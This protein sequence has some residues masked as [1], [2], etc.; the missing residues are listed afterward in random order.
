MDLKNDATYRR[1]EITAEQVESIKKDIN[2]FR[3]V[4]DTYFDSIF[5][6]LYRRSDN[7]AL[8]SELSSN[9]FL[10]ALENIKKY[11]YRGVPFSSW[12]YRI[13]ANELN[14]FYRKNSKVQVFSIEEERIREV[15]HDDLGEDIEQMIDSLKMYLEE[16]KD[17]E[18]NILE[19]RFYEGLEFTEI[20]YVLEKKESAV[21]M[22]LYRSL[23]KLR[24]KF[25]SKESK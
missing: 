22:R 13:A 11:E 1:N 17:E 5:R 14:K 20:A 21:K 8:A 24:K 6:F 25:K 9:T 18:L 16:L 12:L 4:Y 19:L 3:V 23:E 15:V 10:K 7:E 2:Q